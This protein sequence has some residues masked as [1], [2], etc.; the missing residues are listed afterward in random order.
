M[1]AYFSDQN[2]ENFQGWQSSLAQ[3]VSQLLLHSPPA[4]S[5]HRHVIPSDSNTLIY[6]DDNKNLQLWEKHPK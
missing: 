6:P 5:Q 3:V 2:R 4:P 1:E